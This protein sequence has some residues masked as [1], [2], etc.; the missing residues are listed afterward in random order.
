MRR[1]FDWPNGLV[2]QRFPTCC[3][4]GLKSADRSCVVANADWKSAIQ[5]VGNLRYV[6]GV[7]SAQERRNTTIRLVLVPL[8]MLSMPQQLAVLV[9]F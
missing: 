5:Q 2:W 9:N 7:R 6:S 1:K 4:A 3:I 8:D